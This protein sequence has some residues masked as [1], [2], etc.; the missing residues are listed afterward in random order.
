MHP[1]PARSVAQESTTRPRDF[2]EI[3]RTPG[4]AKAPR[5]DGRA[6]LACV[7]DA[8]T[9]GVSTGDI[10]ADL[11]FKEPLNVYPILHRLRKLGKIEQAI[12]PERYRAFV[13]WRIK[14]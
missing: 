9:M 7:R 8:G 11:Q 1:T 4:P 13:L 5:N 10:T 3:L 14:P 6:V 2:G 12:P